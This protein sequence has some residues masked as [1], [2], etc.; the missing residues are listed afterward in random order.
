[1]NTYNIIELIE[2]L[3]N[4]PET[5][6]EDLFRIE[7]AYLS[8]LNRQPGV[9]PKTLEN[10]LA[11]DPG[12]FCEVIRLVYRSTKETKPGRKLSEQDDAIIT[13]A[14]ELLDGW[15]TP[16]GTQSNGTFLPDD[17]QQWLAQVK[18]ICDESGYLEVALNQIGKVIIHCPTDPGGLWIHHSIADVLNKKSAEIMRKGYNTG[19]YN[20]RGMHIVDPTG[21]PER[22][23]AEEYRQK[24]EQIENA[25]YQRFAVTLRKIS[26]RYSHE[27]EQVIDAHK[28]EL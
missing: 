1:M 5:D 2:A 13:N 19:I 18:K 15:K 21:K 11:S 12:F 23:L 22:K 3:Q 4:D 25:G 16:P 8:L 10:K 7:W 14:S 27:A 26:E 24:A 28:N 6:P 9:L 17:F 20:S